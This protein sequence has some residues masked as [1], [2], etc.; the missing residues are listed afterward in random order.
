MKKRPAGRFCIESARE[1]VRAGPYAAFS[2]IAVSNALLISGM[3]MPKFAPA[4]LFATALAGF[5]EML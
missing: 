1:R 4:A 5:S 3:F 2:H